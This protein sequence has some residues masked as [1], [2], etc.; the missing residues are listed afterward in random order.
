MAK[1]AYIGVPTPVQTLADKTIGDSVYLNVNGV[2]TEF[3]VV[4]QGNP[5]SALYDSSCDGTWLL[6]KDIYEKR[7]WNSSPRNSYSESTIHTYLNSTFLGLFDADIQSVIKQVK[8][9]YLDGLGSVST[10]LTG[11]SGLSTKIF[12]LSMRELGFTISVSYT[13]DDGAVLEYFSDCEVIG[14]DDKRVAL[15]NSTASEWWTRSAQTNTDNTVWRSGIT[16]NNTSRTCTYD[17]G[18]RPAV[19]MPS[20][21][22][23]SSDGTISSSSA[24]VGET[25][26]VARKVK[27]MY[28]GENN[29]A[30]KIK[31]AYIGIGGVARP[32]FSGG[33]L[34][35]YGTITELSAARSYLSAAT[36]GN[37]ALFA[38]GSDG[39]MLAVVDAY[40]T[41]LTRTR[42]TELSKERNYMGSTTI[43]GYALF[44]GGAPATNVVDAYDASLTRT[45]PS[46]LT[47]SRYQLAATT[48]GDYAIFGGGTSGSASNVVNAYDTSLTRSTLTPLYSTAYHLA[49]TTV[50]DYALFAGGVGRNYVNAYN[51][52]LTRSIAAALN[53]NRWQMG[54]ATVGN[55]ALFDGG[56]A[57]SNTNGVTT[58]EVYDTSLTK[59]TAT[60]LSTARYQLAAT[61]VGDYAL[62]GGGYNGSWIDVVD[63]YDVSLTRTTATELS[64]ARGSL[65]ATT[66]GDYALFGGGNYSTT[67]TYYSPV[68][69]AYIVS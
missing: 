13:K 6:M 55:Y 8:I 34:A 14:D 23:V 43:G 28:I 25:V 50:G 18:I 60:N 27:K 44:G 46:V 5:D 7:V 59:S 2:R 57:T 40:D 36:V 3:M 69:D 41:S 24:S 37:Y 4:N 62:F 67:A 54:A 22:K 33:E 51:S 9:P 58:V 49:A 64:R 53:E 31:K 39:D 35:Y 66:I 42:A 48:V 65:A 17:D 10:I 12:L 15:Y 63:S 1:G 30:H 56:C 45:T 38:G 61:T 19:I 52:S 16:G 32:C 68:V 29:T 26:N 20:T 11:A 47:V 21:L